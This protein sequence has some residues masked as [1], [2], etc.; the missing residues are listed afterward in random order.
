MDKLQR[1][2]LILLLLALAGHFALDALTGVVA[3][4]GGEAHAP[5]WLMAAPAL[6]LWVRW[7]VWRERSTLEAARWRPAA[8][9]RPPIGAARR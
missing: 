5:L 3:L 7:L 2:L 4:H 6:L 1:G 9:W 8:L